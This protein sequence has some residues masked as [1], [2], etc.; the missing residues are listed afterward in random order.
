MLQLGGQEAQPSIISKHTHTLTEQQ[1]KTRHK[2]VREHFVVRSAA[3]K[4]GRSK[5][6]AL[7]S[8][9]YGAELPHRHPGGAIPLSIAHNTHRITHICPPV[10]T[11]RRALSPRSTATGRAP[12]RA[13]PQY[14]TGPGE[15]AAPTLSPRSICDRPR[16]ASLSC[17]WS[18]SRKVA[19]ASSVDIAIVSSSPPCELRV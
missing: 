13:P 16:A 19:F 2:N 6:A 4:A 18:Y 5:G 15:R 8:S 7:R 9:R 1:N 10:Y 11:G 17:F 12:P 14:M 3:G